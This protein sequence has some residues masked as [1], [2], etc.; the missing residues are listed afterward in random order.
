MIKITSMMETRM[1]FPKFLP[2]GKYIFIGEVCL[3]KAHHVPQ[4]LTL[5]TLF[6]DAKQGA[7]IH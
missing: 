5:F 6:P 3:H 4:R 7:G 2:L 1:Y